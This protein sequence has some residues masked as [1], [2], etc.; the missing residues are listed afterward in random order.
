MIWW[1]GFP[2]QKVDDIWT[3]ALPLLRRGFESPEIADRYYD[4]CKDGKA[5]LWGVFEDQHILAAMLTEIVTIGGR[6]V[7]NV[8]SIGGTR[9]KEWFHFMPLLEQWAREN[10][11]AA[12][13]HANCRLGWAKALKDYETTRITLE[14]AL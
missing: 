3:Q 13:R 5:Q 10:G 4:K 2:G 14:K 11:C 1:T 12:M 9:M 8:I 7:C 6:K